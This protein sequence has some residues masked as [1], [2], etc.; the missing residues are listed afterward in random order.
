LNYHIILFLEKYGVK[1]YKICHWVS[2]DHHHNSSE[3]KWLYSIIT[4]SSQLY[5]FFSLLLLLLSFSLLMVYF[6][7]SLL[8]S[9]NIIIDSPTK[10][11]K[12]TFNQTYPQIWL[13]IT[14]TIDGVFLHSSFW[15]TF[16]ILSLYFSLFLCRFHFRSNVS[17][18]SSIIFPWTMNVCK[19]SIKY[20]RYRHDIISF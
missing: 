14:T 1:V 6:T 10:N 13:E 9:T 19:I 12:Q 11:T 18:I 16:S 2:L 3:F 8:S 20:N 5:F 15:F 4:L 17:D 7:V